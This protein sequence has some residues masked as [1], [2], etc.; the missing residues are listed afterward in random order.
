[1]EI[2]KR[3]LILI[4]SLSIFALVWT[5][6]MMPVLMTSEYFKMLVPPLQYLILNLGF[7]ILFVTIIGS[8]LSYLIKKELDFVY[9]TRLGLSMWLGASLI[10]DLLQPPYYVGLNGETLLDVP[11]ALTGTAVDATVKWV[12]EQFGVRGCL[13]FFC[14]YL[15][16]PVIVVV[17]MAVLLTGKKFIEIFAK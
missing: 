5:M 3:E 10:Y 16:T 12:W 1:M 8:T 15:F 6:L 2:E 14:V 9:A 17:C 11:N 7:I 4:V 13:L